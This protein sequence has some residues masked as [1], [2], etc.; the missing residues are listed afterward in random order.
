M[1]SRVKFGRGQ[2]ESGAL[3]VSCNCDK[4]TSQENTRFPMKP[5]R[6]SVCRKTHAA[7]E[8][9][10]E[11][12]ADLTSF[13]G[14]HVFARLFATVDLKTRLRRC[15]A[16]A[17]ISPIYGHATVVSVL[18]VGLL[19]GYRRLRDL[20]YYRDDPMVARTLGLRRLPDVATV[21]RTLASCDVRSV[22]KLGRLVGELTLDRLTELGLSRVTL[23]FDGTVVSTGRRAEG[24]A[25]GYNRNKKGRRSYY[26][27][28]CTVAQTGQVLA[29]LHRAGNV[30]D[31]NGAEALIEASIE[32]VRERLP[33]AVIEVRMDGA[34]FGQ[35]LIARLEE[36]G[37]E[38]SISVPFERLSEL[39]ETI[40]RR[41]LWESAGED[42]AYFEARHRPKSWKIS[43]RFV[44]VRS[45]VTV[46]NKG[47]VQLDL[48]EPQER[49]YEFKVIVTNKELTA[50]RLTRYHE[51]RGSQEAVFAELKTNCQMDH[52]PTRRLAGN[53]IYMLCAVLAH[54]LGRE[55]QMRTRPPDRRTGAKRTALW[56]LATMETLRRTIVQRAGRLVSPKGKLTLVMSANESVRTEIVGYLDALDR[57]A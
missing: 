20:D 48:F 2:S 26:P 23:D 7:V 49:G 41:A 46:R 51:G 30:H 13:A 37:V 47:P 56:K 27:L 39:K 19:L 3:L 54:N 10:F 22:A 44:V 42:R 34:F 28:V 43:P 52:V 18:L 5:T 55:L 32:R 24:S 25:V 36:L 29:V 57:A 16:H 21:S 4:T 31:S 12:A 9:R 38:Y 6:A 50:P 17:G 45:S 8:L 33:G 53:Q 40:E 1:R 11:Q 14:L 35:A 15:F